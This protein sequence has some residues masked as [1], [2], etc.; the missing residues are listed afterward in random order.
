[1]VNCLDDEAEVNDL[2]GQPECS[3]YPSYR[4]IAEPRL[5]EEALNILVDAKDPL[6]VCGQGALSSGAA[7][8]S[9]NYLKYFK[10]R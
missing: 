4:S 7:P 5:I 2:Y 6:M 9:R 1:M 10:Y 3:C 8:L